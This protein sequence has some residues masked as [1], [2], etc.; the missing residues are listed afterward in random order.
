MESVDKLTRFRHDSHKHKLFRTM[1]LDDG[2]L[3]KN[4]RCR[5]EIVRQEIVYNCPRCNYNLCAHC[6]TLPTDEDTIIELDETDKDIKEDVLFLLKNSVPYIATS[7]N[8]VQN[9]YKEHEEAKEAKGYKKYKKPD[10]DSDVES[11]CCTICDFEKEIERRVCENITI[12]DGV[13]KFDFTPDG[14][15]DKVYNFTVNLSNDR[16]GVEIVTNITVDG[17]EEVH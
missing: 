10:E 6:F 13:I 16:T 1:I 11:A 8:T 9:F 3:C 4:T 5:R 7:V 14:G 15:E 12:N 2:L 17:I